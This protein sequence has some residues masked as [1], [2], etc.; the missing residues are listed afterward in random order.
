MTFDEKPNCLSSI[1]IMYPNLMQR[2][3]YVNSTNEREADLQLA[4]RQ[5]FDGESYNYCR[6]FSPLGAQ[7][8]LY[9]PNYNLELLINPQ[10][11]NLKPN[12]IAVLPNE[13]ILEKFLCDLRFPCDM[14]KVVDD[15]ID[16]IGSSYYQEI[17]IKIQRSRS[18][19][20]FELERNVF[21]YQKPGILLEKSDDEI[22]LTL[23]TGIN[24]KE[25]ETDVS[26]IENSQPVRTKPF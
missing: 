16:T 25:H 15:I 13:S 12:Q 17:K 14:L 6:Y 22:R 3:S 10:K 18:R 1:T 2:F 9:T 21:K 26:K 19:S 23:N 4:S 20:C 5:V 11:E 8:V 7:I 24:W